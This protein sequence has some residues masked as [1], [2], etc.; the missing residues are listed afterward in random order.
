MLKTIED[1]QKV[2]YT[3]W[4]QAR[5][6]GLKK[7]SRGLIRCGPLRAPEDEASEELYEGSGR[8][9]LTSPVAAAI[10]E[11]DDT[12]ALY[13]PRVCHQINLVC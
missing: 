2:Q 3:I 6:K 13:K 10:G 1:L 9:H 8:P 5:R 4:N 7:W 12:L 11:L